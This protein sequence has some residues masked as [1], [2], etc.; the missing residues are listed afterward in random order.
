M[1]DIK[2]IVSK[3][4]SEL[5]QRTGMTQLELAEKLNY[6]D[7]AVSK[8]ERGESIPDVSVLVSI[9]DMFNVPLDYMVKEDFPLQQVKEA[10][11]M[12]TEEKRRKH[13]II[14]SMSIILVWSI[15]TLIFIIIS[16]INC[17]FGFQIVSFLYALPVTMIVWL[18]FN[19][20]WFNKRMNYLIVSLLMWSIL[21]AFH[22]SFLWF[23]IHV[24][25]FYLLGIP[26]QLVI[27]LWSMLKKRQQLDKKD[28]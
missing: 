15:A 20:V 4:I 1:K 28:A 16:V 25:L 24:E 13:K 12:D 2:L 7:K 5:R 3:R 27:W 11:G 6:S 19:S 10:L 23:D 18:V 17:K 26:G 22:L 8:W 9:A 21:V 14:T